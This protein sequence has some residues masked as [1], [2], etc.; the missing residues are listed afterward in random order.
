VTVVWITGLPS[1]GKSTLAARLRERLARALVLDG[2]EVRDAL[3]MHGYDAAARDAFYRALAGLAALVARQGLVAIVAATAPTR[4]QRQHA[5]ALAPRFVEVFVDTPL[6]E[7][8]RRDAKGLYAAARGGAAPTLPGGGA[9]YERP[10]A[11][12]VIAH[13]GEDDAAIAAIVERVR[14]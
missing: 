1:S 5:R 4:E 2:D 3:G 8:A 10:E 7:C 12:D 11:P 13:G 6:A 9:A 14:A